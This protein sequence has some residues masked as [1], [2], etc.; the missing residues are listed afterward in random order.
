M[1][2]SKRTYRVFFYTLL[3][4]V[5]AAFFSVQF[6]FNFETFSKS[7][8]I[9]NYTH[10]TSLHTNHWSNAEFTKKSPAG[11][12]S[13]ISFRLNKRFQQEDMPPPRASQY[14]RTR[15]L[16]RP[17]LT[18]VLSRRISVVCNPGE[19]TPPWPPFCCLL[20]RATTFFIFKQIIW[21]LSV[22][23]SS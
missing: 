9:P 7:G 14:C 10:S 12:S 3:L 23:E 1:S 16:W 4:A 22:A 17:Q 6:F 20:I 13:G 8:P 21:S 15:S 11:S 2:I 18:R 5:Y 19:P